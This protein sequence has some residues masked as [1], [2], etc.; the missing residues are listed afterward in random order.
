MLSSYTEN[1]GSQIYSAFDPDMD[2]AVLNYFRGTV[3]FG[4]SVYKFLCFVLTSR[5]AQ[6][7]IQNVP[8]IKCWVRPS[9][10]HIL[11]GGQIISSRSVF[12]FTI[13]QNLALLVSKLANVKC[14]VIVPQLTGLSILSKTFH[15]LSAAC[16]IFR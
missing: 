5:F 12:H 16:V 14:S 11:T 7:P 3:T 2:S 10:Y 4:C 13:L 6:T 1:E 9:H 15:P 8:W